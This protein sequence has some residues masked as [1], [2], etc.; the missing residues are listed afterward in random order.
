MR[1]VWKKAKPKRRRGVAAASAAV[2]AIGTAL[3]VVPKMS[4]AVVTGSPSGFQSNDGNMTVD[5]GTSFSDWNCFNS[6]DFTGHAG[7]E[8][9]PSCNSALKATNAVAIHPD[10]NN[11]ANGEVTWTSGQKMD[12]NC[13]S[14]TN[15][16]NV[17]NKDDF[18][19][20][21]SYN[22]TQ[23]ASPY[24][25]F[26]YGAEIRKVA[27]GNSSGNVELN[28]SAGTPGCPITR[29]G[30]DWLLAFDFTGG[31]TSLQFHALAWIT[32]TTGPGS[33]FGG[34]SGTCYIGHD[35]PPCWGAHAIT[36]GS[37]A[38]GGGTIAVAGCAPPSTGNDV[39]GCAN[40][41][42]IPGNQNGIS[43]QALATEQ[44]AEFGVNLTKVLNVCTPFKQEVWES[45]SS[46]SSFTSNPEDI[47]IEAHDIQECGSI[48]VVKHTSPR[49]QDQS[50]PFTTSLNL[51]PNSFSLN[52]SGNTTGDNTANTQTYGNVPPGTYTITEG[53]NPAGFSFHS[54]SCLNNG[55]PASPGI[56]GKV[57]T[58][59]LTPHDNYVCTYVNDAY[60]TIKV[61]KHTDPRG[62][63]QSFSFTSDVPV[64]ANASTGT[65]SAFSLN[66]SGNKTGDNSA[67]T[68]T[69]TQVPVGSYQVTEGSEP[70]GWTLESLVCTATDAGSSGT[71]DGTTPAQADI[72]V[73]AG[74]TVTCTYKNLQPTGAINITKV[75]SKSSLTVLAD[76]TFEICTNPPQAPPSNPTGT[77]SYGSWNPCSAPSG[78]TNPLPATGSNGVTCVS[79][80]PW[81]GS[82]RSYYVKELAPAP[83]GYALDPDTVTV[84][85]NADGTC[86]SGAITANVPD[87]PLTDLTITASSEVSG[88][89]DSTI[90]CV[91]ATPT[92]IGNSPQGPAGSATV[93][94][95]GLMP[96][97]YTCTVNVDP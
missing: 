54:V 86:S 9:T 38:P 91:D 61:I 7:L 59:T 53:A 28:Q 69:I 82:G 40:Q 83:T 16:G 35:T 24:N 73:D 5:G 64:T 15:N 13:P 20:L 22:E 49:G 26:L 14:L 81:S 62:L 79:G 78:V 80:L 96:G 17:P 52:D 76:A 74:G 93:S 65:A 31:G 92:D 48:T 25:S 77:P 6:A 85:V 56:S 8:T 45:R 67:N 63:N 57:V 94:A 90:S 97:T 18:T 42:M 2:L 21:A 87:T 89:T 46:G 41:T 23:S 4:A 70:T 47:E 51:T 50:F 36:S 39:E 11:G 95:T 3:V 55:S 34:N 84:N 44:F 32:T 29:T 72:T 19:D 33:Q 30:G 75:S 88:G 37:P 60:G 43:G 12:A 27:N 10:G 1:A 68:E 58:I 66:D 71:Q